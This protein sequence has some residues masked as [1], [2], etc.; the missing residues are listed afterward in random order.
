V[1]KDGIIQGL[2]NYLLDRRGLDVVSVSSPS[3]ALAQIAA[4]S[5]DAIVLEPGGSDLL[6]SI[7][8]HDPSMVERVVL[9]T[10]RRD[11]PIR[12]PVHAVLQKP[13]D[14]A[15]LAR[16]VSEAVTRGA[17]ANPRR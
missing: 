15:E 3:E 6:E 4:S 8:Q 12:R 7:H 13:F 1:E 17:I 5:F 14:V 11:L 2:I 9:V 16:I 10:T